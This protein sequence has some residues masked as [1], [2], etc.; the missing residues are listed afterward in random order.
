MS[1]FADRVAARAIEVRPARILLSVL[2][3]PFY[4]LGWL[5]GLVIV[6]VM[7]TVAAVQLGVSD[8]RARRGPDV[9]S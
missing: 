2:A 7:W 4:A 1:S 6:A 3:A 5:V 9:A 8:A